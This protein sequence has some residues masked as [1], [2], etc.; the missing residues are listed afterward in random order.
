MRESLINKL[1]AGD[2]GSVYARMNKEEEKSK[3]LCYELFDD[4]NETY[5]R[6]PAERDLGRIEEEIRGKLVEILLRTRKN[7]S[8]KNKELQEMMG[9]VL[10]TVKLSEEF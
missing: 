2:I 3:P 7:E 5:R 4:K 1:I 6:E 8:D 9:T 10:N